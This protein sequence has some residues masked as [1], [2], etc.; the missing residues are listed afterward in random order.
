MLL[1]NDM[2]F[3]RIVLATLLALLVLTSIM[4]FFGE[5]SFSAYARSHGFV[6]KHHDK[7]SDSSKEIL[8]HK[9]T[10]RTRH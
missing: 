2:K 10:H 3:N 6:K 5:D 9:T 8:K 1:N 7:Q 4:S